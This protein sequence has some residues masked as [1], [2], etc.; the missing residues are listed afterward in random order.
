MQ[1]QYLYDILKMTLYWHNDT[2]S[3]DILSSD[4]RIFLI[5]ALLSLSDR[6][7]TLHSENIFAGHWETVVDCMENIGKRQQGLISQL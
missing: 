4:K 6:H 5:W 2:S 3:M 7:L 1:Y